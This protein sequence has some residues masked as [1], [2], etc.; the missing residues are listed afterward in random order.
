MS[1]RVKERGGGDNIC[2]CEGK[3]EGIGPYIILDT[4]N[5]I[6]NLGGQRIGTKS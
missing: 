1:V 6:K 3:V 4:V 5:T 2:A